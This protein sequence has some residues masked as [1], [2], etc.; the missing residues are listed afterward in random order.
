MNAHM[1]ALDRTDSNA[2]STE[3]SAGKRHI[4]AAVGDDVTTL[5]EIYHDNTNIAIW[6]R[7][8]SDQDLSATESLLKRAPGLA[9]NLMV[10][11]E[12]VHTEISRV[13]P[14]EHVHTLAQDVTQL[15]EMFCFLFDL[16]RVGLRLS[17]LDKAMCPRFHVDAV[18]CRLV[19]TYGGAG[20]QWLPHP[21]VDRSKLGSGNQ[22]LPDNESGLY[23]A[24][25]DVQTL[26]AGDVAL[27]KGEAWSGNE[28]AGLVHRSPTASPCERRLLLTIDFGR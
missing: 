11:P 4:R 18:P 5:P 24:A 26:E 25:N 13:L 8:F 3:R 19:T 17:A 7:R 21:K 20:T 12:N 1:G 15:A 14:A 27:L 2:S 22:G 28:G 9:L 16:K 6:Q 10:S 23:S